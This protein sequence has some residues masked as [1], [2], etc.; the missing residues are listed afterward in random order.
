MD[1]IKKRKMANT[2][3]R[4]W[5]VRIWTEDVVQPL[6]TLNT[7]ME[8]VQGAAWSPVSATIIASISANDIHLWDIKHKIFVPASTA[9]SPTDTGNLM[10]QF[11]ASG[12]NL[13]IGDG[14]GAVHVYGLQD[15]PF[16]PFYQEIALIQAIKKALVTR[17]ELL[18]ILK[19]IGKPFY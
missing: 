2:S 4:N 13:V 3:T 14:E 18:K 11:T 7:S 12:L 6:L 10:I 19:K 17:P 1:L 8:S 5:C 16:S 15:M 9:T